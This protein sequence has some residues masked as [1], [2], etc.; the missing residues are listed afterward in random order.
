MINFCDVYFH[1][2][3]L[4]KLKQFV[5]CHFFK[6]SQCLWLKSGFTEYLNWRN[7]CKFH[8]FCPFLRKLILRKIWNRPFS[9]VHLAKFFLFLSFNFLYHKTPCFQETI[10]KNFQT[11]HDL[12]KFILK[13]ILHYSIHKSLSKKFRFFP[14]VKVSLIKVTRKLEK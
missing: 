1:Y 10:W 14:V 8:W 12:Q 11:F 6:K 3:N 7:F 4:Q 5:F 9:K 13:N 2:L